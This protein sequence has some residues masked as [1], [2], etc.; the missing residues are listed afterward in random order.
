MHTGS[1]GSSEEDLLDAIPDH[2]SSFGRHV[3]SVG[4]DQSNTVLGKC[5]LNETRLVAEVQKLKTV[6][7]IKTVRKFW[8]PKQ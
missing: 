6:Q 8:S 5:R 1:D 3:T 7:T 4:L 2:Y